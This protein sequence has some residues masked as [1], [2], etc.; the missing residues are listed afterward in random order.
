M[1]DWSDRKAAAI[2]VGMFIAGGTYAALIFWLTWLVL[3]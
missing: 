1:D 2:A 3:S